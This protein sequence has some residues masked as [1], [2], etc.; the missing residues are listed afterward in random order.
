[1]NDDGPTSADFPDQPKSRWQEYERRRGL[2]RQRQPERGERSFRTEGLWYFFGAIKG[3]GWAMAAHIAALLAGVTHFA[4]AIFSLLTI[5]APLWSRTDEPGYFLYVYSGILV[6]I[7]AIIGTIQL[8]GVGLSYVRNRALGWPE[9][10]TR[11][12]FIAATVTFGLA[13]L[14]GGLFFAALFES[15]FVR[16]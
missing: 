10:G 11:T 4:L 3:Q 12:M 16:R 2:V 6:I 5:V 7:P 13:I 9:E 15:A 14:G 1:M 8:V